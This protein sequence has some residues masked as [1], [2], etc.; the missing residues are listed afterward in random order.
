LLPRIFIAKKN[1]FA[2]KQFVEPAR[3]KI[4]LTAVVYK[5]LRGLK[6]FFNAA[7]GQ[8]TKLCK[9]LYYQDKRINIL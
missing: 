3:R 1:R 8:N 4:F 5:I 7:G 6:K 2:T 9:R